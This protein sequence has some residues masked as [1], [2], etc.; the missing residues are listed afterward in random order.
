MI[1]KDCG[2]VMESG[3]EYNPKRNN[4]DKGYKR[5]NRCRKCHNIIYNNFPNFQE[6]LAKEFGKR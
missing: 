2:I 4:K 6:I 3:T 5:Y 1:C